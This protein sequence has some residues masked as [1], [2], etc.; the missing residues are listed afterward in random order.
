M[1]RIRNISGEPLNVPSI[2]VTVQPGDVANVP[3]SIAADFSE[4]YW[5][6]DGER[7][8]T[9]TEHGAVKDVNAS[10]NAN[11]EEGNE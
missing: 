7:E 5:E 8:N 6:V 3:D 9:D 4:N 2:G 10:D 11:T 1:R